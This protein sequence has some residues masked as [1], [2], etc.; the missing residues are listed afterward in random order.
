MLIFSKK[1]LS[2]SAQNVSGLVGIHQGQVSWTFSVLLLLPL[3][4]LPLP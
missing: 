1:N 2:L 4:Y 3:A